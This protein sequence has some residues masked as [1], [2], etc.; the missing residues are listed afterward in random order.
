MPKRGA[1]IAVVALAAAGCGTT[2]RTVSITTTAPP[3]TE[4][5]TTA[6]LRS[7][8]VLAVP[9]VGRFYGRCP[10]RARVW[11]LRF[12]VPAGSATDIVSYKI[13][14]GPVRRVNVSPGRAVTFHLVARA[15]RTPEPAD[16]I[17]QH[18][19]TTVATT[20]PLDVHIS[21]GTEAQ[22]SRV[23][24]HLALATIG[25]ETAACGLVGSRVE[26]RTYSN[27]TP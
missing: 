22:Y 9:S 14:A 12:S 16:R 7:D 25:G 6:L 5:A 23:D 24:V 26:A 2:T 21:Q 15:A 1:V 19:A 18:P 17:S 27:G 4:T 20:P 8:E 13:G 3:V 11:A 10:R